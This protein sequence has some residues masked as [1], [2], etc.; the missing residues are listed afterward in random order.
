[1]YWYR[2]Q[3]E[4]NYKKKSMQLETMTTSALSWWDSVLPDEEMVF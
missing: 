4:W 1:M 3:I 2:L